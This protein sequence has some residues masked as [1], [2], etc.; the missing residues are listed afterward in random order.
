VKPSKLLV[1]FVDRSGMQWMVKLELQ[2]H[3][4]QNY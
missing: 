3:F 1:Q 2:L 4:N